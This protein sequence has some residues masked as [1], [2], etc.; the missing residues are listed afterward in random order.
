MVVE[1]SERFYVDLAAHVTY[2]VS[3]DLDFVVERFVHLK[4]GVTANSTERSLEAIATSRAR[5]AYN[6]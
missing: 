2:A 5:G 4:R 6:Y 1:E 3:D